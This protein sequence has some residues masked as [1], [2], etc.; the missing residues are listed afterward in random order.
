MGFNLLATGGTQRYLAAKG[1]ESEKV[2]KVTEGRPNIVDRIID[3]DVHLVINTTFGRQEVAD[4]FSLR[5]EALMHG[6]PYYT[7]VQGARMAIEAL[8]ALARGPLPVR[9][10]QEYLKPSA[11]RA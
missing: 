4:S 2:L 6:R 9:A 11:K 1:I 8:E 7:T 10:L 3:G 5:R